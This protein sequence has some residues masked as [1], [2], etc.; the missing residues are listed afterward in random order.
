[1]IRN[2]KQIK[3]NKTKDSLFSIL[4]PSWNNL[5]YLKLCIESI[6]KNSAFAHQI[7]VI[8]NEGKDGTLQ[9]IEKE[10]DLDYI[11]T[12]QNIGICYALNVCRS[13]V[14]TEY[15][16]YANDDMYFLPDWDISLKEEVEKIGHKNFML[17]ATMI[18]PTGQNA[19]GIQVDYGTDIATF[20]EDDLLRDYKT[21]FRKDWS[22]ST[23]PPV[24]IHID[25]WDMVGGMS[26]EYSPGMYSDPDLAR[27]LWEVGV[28]IFRGKGNS[29]VYHFGCKSTGRVKK[30]K[31][32][33]T[34]TLKWGISAKTFMEQY[35]LRGKDAVDILPEKELGKGELFSQFMKR[36]KAC[37]SK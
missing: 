12:E 31:G 9:Y 15:I 14:K 18:E 30:N 37:L 8:V 32:S 6:Q 23:W 16:L 11:Y 20:R 27:K 1:M 17:S 33:K 29:L 34:F 22:G 10:T 35:L 26:I 25:N 21:L 13:Q 3:R 24:L 5:P 7:I 2:I 28:R 36:I 19:C 4:I